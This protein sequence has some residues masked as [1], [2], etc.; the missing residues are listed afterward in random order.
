MNSPGQ[1]GV[2]ERRLRPELTGAIH[3]RPAPVVSSALRADDYRQQITV[4]E[5]A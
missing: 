3:A 1:R 5:I 4:K 2:A